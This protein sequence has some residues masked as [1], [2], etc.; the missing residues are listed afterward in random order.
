MLA[1]RR[2]P[3]TWQLMPAELLMKVFDVCQTDQRY[4]QPYGR[5]KILA[6]VSSICRR[7]RDVAT[8][9]SRQWSRI[10]VEV[11]MVYPALP[12]LELHVRRSCHWPLEITI[13][14]LSCRGPAKA[15]TSNDEQT[16]YF[17]SV[18]A[19]LL[20]YLHRW[21][22]LSIIQTPSML[23]AVLILMIHISFQDAKHL[24]R[25]ELYLRTRIEIEDGLMSTIGQAPVL[26]KLVLQSNPML[27]SQPGSRVP[28]FPSWDRLEHVNFSHRAIF[29]W[30]LFSLISKCTSAV[31][32]RLEGLVNFNGH[33]A[34]PPS[35]GTTRSLPK[36]RALHLTS[37]LDILAPFITSLIYPNIE[38]L[39]FTLKP[40]ERQQ[41]LWSLL[42]LILQ[43]M[44]VLPKYLKV[45]VEYTLPYP[46]VTEFFSVSSIPDIPI[47]QLSLFSN[48]TWSP[49]IRALVKHSISSL[50]RHPGRLTAKQTRLFVG[51]ADPHVMGT[52]ERDCE[53]QDFGV[54]VDL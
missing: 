46:A 49:K 15:R 13:G 42:A 37:T 36:L 31:T 29:W 19:F 40:E 41:P 52:H 16:E 18:L 53:L 7:W 3:T 17:Q 48:V 28:S 2:S 27:F 21:K 11:T 32:V 54:S 9:D 51:W 43:Q 14:S 35:P 10:H 26:R 44:E 34:F 39:H 23:D 25:V 5:Y 22:T 50:S 30:E 20:P 4:E 12:M 6:M 24:E 47:V 1:G 45:D 8:S 33:H 38:V